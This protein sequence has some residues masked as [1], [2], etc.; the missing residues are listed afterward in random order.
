M[1]VVLFTL[2][3]GYFP[4][5]TADLKDQFYAFLLQ[6]ERDANGINS[7]Y[8]ETL[9]ASDLSNDFKDLMQ[10]IFSMDG[11]KRLAREP[12]KFSKASQSLDG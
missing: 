4:F 7:A 1:G 9:K 11:N 3:V 6:G 12:N 2:V 10:R 5:S 8:W